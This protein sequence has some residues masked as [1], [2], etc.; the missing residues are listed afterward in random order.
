M[1]TYVNHLAPTRRWVRSMAVTLAILVAAHSTS[2]ADLVIYDNQAAP[3]ATTPFASMGEFIEFTPVAN[4]NVVQVAMGVGLPMAGAFDLS[5]VAEFYDTFDSNAPAGTNV[6]SDLLQAFVIQPKVEPIVVNSA[7]ATGLI[8]SDDLRPLDLDF[9]LPLDGN[10]FVKFT[11]IDD[12]TG[13]PAD[14]D[15]VANILLSRGGVTTGSSPDGVYG[16]LNGDGM[17]EATEFFDF[18]GGLDNIRLTL[19][20][21]QIPEPSS[22]LFMLVVS[23]GV[24]IYSGAKARIG[25]VLS[26][27]LGR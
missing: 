9:A 25:R 17:L 14:T 4:H 20:V 22:M 26:I 5:V 12:T 15:D 23:M 7:P 24:L 1:E 13:N 21:A 11:V 16:D 6:Y 2:W 10:M 19:T 27:I 8:T 18:D 3:P